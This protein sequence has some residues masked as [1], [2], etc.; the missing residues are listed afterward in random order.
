M[1]G[2]QHHFPRRYATTGPLSLCAGCLIVC[3][4]LILKLVVFYLLGNT[5]L[6]SLIDESD[7]WTRNILMPKFEPLNDAK[8]ANIDL[9]VLTQPHSSSSLTSYPLFVMLGYTLPNILG[10]S[11]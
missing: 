7:V 6:S 9:K 10:L 1:S 11:I 5:L 2:L 8:E 3:F 4:I